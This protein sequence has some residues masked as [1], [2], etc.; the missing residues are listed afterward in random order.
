MASEAVKR[1]QYNGNAHSIREKLI[2]KRRGYK[3][4]KEV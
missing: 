2:K 1:P 3:V 4:F